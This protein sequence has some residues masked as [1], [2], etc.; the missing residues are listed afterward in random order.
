MAKGC[1]KKK[2]VFF[3]LPK[4][5]FLLAKFFGC[6]RKSFR[7]RPKENFDACPRSEDLIFSELCHF[8]LDP[9]SLTHENKV[10]NC[11]KKLDDQKV[12]FHEKG[13]ISVNMS[14]TDLRQ[15]SKFS[16]G[17]YPKL[18]PWHPKDLVGR[19]ICLGESKISILYFYLYISRTFGLTENGITQWL[20]VLQTW[21]RAQNFLWFDT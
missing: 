6:Q 5:F 10:K 2:V 12:C 15:V 4:T 9:F 16:L 20:F 11:Q 8:L 21:D 1:Q 17:R 14:P 13:H 3:G 18:F 19:K 7:Y